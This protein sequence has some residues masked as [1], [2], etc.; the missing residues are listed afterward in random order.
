MSSWDRE[1][2]PISVLRACIKCFHLMSHIG[3]V[4]N[5]R[6]V[7]D[8]SRNLGVLLDSQTRQGRVA[9]AYAVNG[10]RRS[11][12]M[13]NPGRRWKCNSGPGRIKN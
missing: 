4:L 11:G 5:N 2:N 12:S 10:Y 7:G 6:A 9:V 13:L 8:W 1:Y 3:I